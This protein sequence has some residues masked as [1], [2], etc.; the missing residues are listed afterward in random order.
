MLDSLFE[1]S[2]ESMPK[3]NPFL[4]EKL[5]GKFI[6]KLYLTAFLKELLF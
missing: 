2:V 6:N 4:E 5:E 3:E 1:G